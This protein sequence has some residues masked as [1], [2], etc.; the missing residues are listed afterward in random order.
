MKKNSIKSKERA[1]QRAREYVQQLCVWIPET[2]K[3]NL[4]LARKVACIVWY[5]KISNYV[6][7]DPFVLDFVRSTPFDLQYDPTEVVD[8]LVND[9]GYKREFATWR[10][11]GRP[12]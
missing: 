10:M 4:P 9:F 2:S 7:T 1:E 8:A 12:E 3:T 11:N 5:D 6:I